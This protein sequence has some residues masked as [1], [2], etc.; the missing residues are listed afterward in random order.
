VTGLLDA[1]GTEAPLLRDAVVACLGPPT[2]EAAKSRGL[3]VAVQPG[4][5]RMDALVQAIVDYVKKKG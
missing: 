5:Q 2:A 4:Q 1:L 3:H